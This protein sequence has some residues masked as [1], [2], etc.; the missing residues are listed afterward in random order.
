MK[1]LAIAAVSALA[2]ALVTPAIACPGA[3]NMQN[4][5]AGTAQSEAPAEA[6][7]AQTP[8]P[9]ADA[10]AEAQPAEVAAAPAAETASKKN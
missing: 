1:S 4:A 7:A 8:M 10:S 5:D 6:A 3:K 2:L 9:A